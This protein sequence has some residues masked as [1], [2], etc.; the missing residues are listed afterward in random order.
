MHV[1]FIG[2]AIQLV[3]QIFDSRLN[4]QNVRGAALRRFSMDLL[5]GLLERPRVRIDPD[6]EL[7]R[8]LARRLVDKAPVSRP[9]IDD[10]PFA[11]M[12]G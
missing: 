11:G 3:R 9:D 5:G 2:D 1:H 6:V 12:L 8:V 7:V 4:E 10:H